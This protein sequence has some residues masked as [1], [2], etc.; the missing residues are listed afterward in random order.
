[1]SFRTDPWGWGRG[2]VSL[3]KQ[4]EVPCYRRLC[5]FRLFNVAPETTARFS[6]FNCRNRNQITPV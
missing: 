4:R 6:H 5:L 3:T 1:M 2:T